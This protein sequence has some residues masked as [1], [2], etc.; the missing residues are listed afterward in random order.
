M[1]KNFFR[2]SNFSIKRRTIQSSETSLNW[3]AFFLEKIKN[4][5]LWKRKK[6]I[7]FQKENRSSK[8]LPFT[9]PSYI[10]ELKSIFVNTTLQPSIEI[11]LFAKETSNIQIYLRDDSK[12][13]FHHSSHLI[14]QGEQPFSI[15]LKNNT[16][17][18]NFIFLQ[19]R[20]NS[21]KTQTQKL[22]IKGLG[23]K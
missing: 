22:S 16:I 8:I 13:T 3:W 10:V 6:T 20:E 18:P 12:K 21:G 2:P 1:Q 15:V 9:P 19:I 23:N 4:W 11:T 14:L 5:N 17:L 7:H